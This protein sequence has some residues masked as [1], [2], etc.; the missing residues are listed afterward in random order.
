MQKLLS[1][2]KT[3][4]EPFQGRGFTS[5]VKDGSADFPARRREERGPTADPKPPKLISPAGTDWEA[6]AARPF[7]RGGLFE[8]SQT[9]KRPCKFKDQIILS[10][11]STV[12]VAKL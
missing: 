7:Q 9:D 1:A 11:R 2:G 10:N 6:S 3:D 4:A 8:K 12:P 5:G